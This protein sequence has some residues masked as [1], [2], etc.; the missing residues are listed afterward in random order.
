VQKLNGAVHKYKGKIAS[1]PVRSSGRPAN[2]THG[3]E[4][5]PALGRAS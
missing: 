3:R 1:V 5:G 4:K 2:T